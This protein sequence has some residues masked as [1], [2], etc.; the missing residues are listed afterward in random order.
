MPFSPSTSIR[1]CHYCRKN[2]CSRHSYILNNHIVC[3]KCMLV[4][5]YL[6]PIFFKRITEA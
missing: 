6:K 3:K 5:K 4:Q 1:S 2:L